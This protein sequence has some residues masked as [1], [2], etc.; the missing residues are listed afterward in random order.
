MPYELYNFTVSVVY[1]SAEQY[2]AHWMMGTTEEGSEGLDL[3]Q[4]TKA[5]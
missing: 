2:A 1:S 4:S 5:L 3:S